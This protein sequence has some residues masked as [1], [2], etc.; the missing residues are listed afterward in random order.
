MQLENEDREGSKQEAEVKRVKF[1][2]QEPTPGI[3]KN[4]AVSNQVLKPR[5]DTNIMDLSEISLSKNTK[6]LLMKY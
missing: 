3:L 4:K 1:A 2:E 6:K 5:D